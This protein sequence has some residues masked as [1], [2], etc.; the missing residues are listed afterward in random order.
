MK[1][2]IMILKNQKILEYKLQPWRLVWDIIV[3]FLLLFAGSLI[4]GFPYAVNLI[5]LTNLGFVGVAHYAKVTVRS[6]E[7]FLPRSKEEFMKA[8]RWDCVLQA[9]F[10]CIGLG[11]GYVLTIYC[12]PHTMNG[13][14]A[15]L[16][17]CMCQTFFLYFIIQYMTNYLS[18]LQLSMGETKENIQ[19]RNFKNT[20][21]LHL[22]LTMV[23][24]AGEVGLVYV[25]IVA[26]LTDVGNDLFPGL[27]NWMHQKSTIGVIAVCCILGGIVEIGY[28]KKLY[29]AL[30]EV[31]DEY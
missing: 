7:F 16:I 17:L 20:S 26:D 11:V 13:R 6:I 31:L 4:R 5:W 14:R 24:F 29:Q 18:K 25:W 12:S 9:G 3:L 30:G 22:I 2:T 19:K 1:R 10:Y 8:I 15:C 21:V 28:F 23:I 27:V